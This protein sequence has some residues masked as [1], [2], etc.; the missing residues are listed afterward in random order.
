MNPGSAKNGVKAE[1]VP[2]F[3]SM[4]SMAV[5][6]CVYFLANNGLQ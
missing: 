5:K 4:L 2:F 3:G 1:D 6:A